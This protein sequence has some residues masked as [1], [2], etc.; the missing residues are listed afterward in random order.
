MRAVSLSL[1]II[2]YDMRL[3]TI[4]FIHKHLLLNAYPEYAYLPYSHLTTLLGSFY[5][6]LLSQ[7]SKQGFQPFYPGIPPNNLVR[8]YPQILLG[9]VVPCL[10]V[11]LSR[12][13]A[14]HARGTARASVP[15]HPIKQHP[16]S[17]PEVIPR[18]LGE[19]ICGKFLSL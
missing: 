15:L 13:V 3:K 2:C 7:E 10:I 19:R 14:E 4:S 9:V 1:A 12:T 11:C 18:Q 6:R 16:Q 8:T 17:P 5:K